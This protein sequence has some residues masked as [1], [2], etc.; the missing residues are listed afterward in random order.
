MNDNNL[1]AFA[2]LEQLG[3]RKKREELTSLVQGVTSN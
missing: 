1:P 2:G 3:E